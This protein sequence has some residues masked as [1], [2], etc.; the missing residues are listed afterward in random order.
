MKIAILSRYQN[1]INR[2]AEVYVSELSKRLSQDNEVEVLFGKDADSLKKVLDG[3]F[4]IVLSINGGMQLLKASVGRFFKPYKL[5][6]SGQAG[7]GRGS[8]WNIVIC[9]PDYFIALT[10]VMATWAKKWAINTQVVTIPNGVDL[11][12]F[13]P[14]GRKIDF[15][16]PKPIILSVGALTTYKHHERLINAVSELERGSL[17]IVGKGGRYKELKSKGDHLLNGR[18]KILDFSHQEMSEVFRGADLF[19]LPSWDREAFGIVYVEA[20]AC[21][22]PV[23]APNDQTRKEIIREAGIFVDVANKKQYAQALHQ[24]LLRNWQNIPRRRAENFSWDEV[25]RK[26]QDLF[27]LK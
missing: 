24:A 15:N 19:S 20:M 5:I 14:L 13:R 9:Q 16:L 3:N 10:S 22:L 12:K 23:V 8:I 26:Y 6:I 4:D 21:N 18:F 27:N 2:G 25:A 7:I 11:E 1:T 17:V